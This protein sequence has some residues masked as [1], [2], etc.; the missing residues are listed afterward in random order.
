MSLSEEQLKKINEEVKAL[1]S[2]SP[3]ELTGET[4]SNYSYIAII[5]LGLLILFSKIKPKIILKKGNHK[6]IDNLRLVVASGFL[7]V[8]IWYIY[9]LLR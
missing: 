5:F 7:A 1:Y 3:I 6:D 4:N 2:S 9:N 8:G